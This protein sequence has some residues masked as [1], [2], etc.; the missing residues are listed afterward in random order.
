MCPNRC[1][2]DASSSDPSVNVRHEVSVGPVDAAGIDISH[3]V[4]TPAKISEARLRMGIDLEAPM[5]P[6]PELRCLV[7]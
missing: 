1:G 2:N 7:R 5:P 4:E 3:P 6:L